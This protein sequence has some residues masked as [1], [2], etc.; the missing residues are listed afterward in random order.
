MSKKILSIDLLKPFEEK[1]GCDYMHWPD[2][3]FLSGAEDVEVEGVLFTWFASLPALKKAVETGC[4]VVFC[5]EP[6]FYNEKAELPPY[7]WLTPFPGD[8]EPELHPNSIK[9]EFIERH[10]LTV[11][12]SHYGWDRFCMFEAFSEALGFDSENLEYDHGWESIFKLPEEMTVKE[13]ALKIKASLDLKG[14]VRIT[15]DLNRKVSKVVNLWGGMGLKDNLYWLNQGIRNGAEVGIAGEMDEF[16]MQFAMEADIPVIETSH[17][18]SEE[19][20]VKYYASHI[21]KLFPELKINIYTLGRP[22]ET[23]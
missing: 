17:Q 3:G 21:Q 11:I 13:L 12:Q 2:G 10:K 5:H 4:N 23:L 9:R 7:R 22:Y 20:G 6:P 15:G 1:I 19:Y 14:T 8:M 18:L 16:F